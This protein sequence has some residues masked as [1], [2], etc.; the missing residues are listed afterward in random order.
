MKVNTAFVR[1]VTCKTINKVPAEKLKRRPICGKCKASLKLYRQTIEAT[2]SSFNQEV[3]AWPGIVFVEFWSPRCGHCMRIKPTVEALAH[4]RA[5]LMKVVT[6]NVDNESSLASRFQIQATPFMM[7][8]R[9]G[10]KL[11]E[12]SGVLPKEQL[13]AWIDSSVLG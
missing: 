7:L 12:I 8:F 6:V 2:V 10:D 3:L 11:S 5:G 4:E 1:C 9:N 13:E